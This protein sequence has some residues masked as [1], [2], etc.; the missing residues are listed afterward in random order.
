MVHVEPRFPSG[1]AGDEIAAVADRHISR[2]AT[3]LVR[4]AR[5]T[6]A[7]EA[8][9]FVWLELGPHSQAP[10]AVMAAGRSP[11]RVPELCDLDAVWIAIYDGDNPRKWGMWRCATAE[12][13]TRHSFT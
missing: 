13:W 8:H 3:K 12:G 6:G 2:K 4:R 10:V 11:T 9:L 5:A 7:S 1:W